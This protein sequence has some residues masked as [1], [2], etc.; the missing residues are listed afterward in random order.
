MNLK[1]RKEEVLVSL[2]N[3]TKYY[4]DRLAVDNISF[5]VG[6]G[7]ILGFLG[8]NGAGK[9]TT[10]R[11]I[12]GY[13]PPTSGKIT[14][15]GINMQENPVEAKKHIGY[16][17]E[18][19]PVYGEMTVISYLKFVARLKRVNRKKINERIEFVLQKCGLENVKNRII[20]NLSRGYRQ[21]VGI[22]Q[23]IVHDPEIIIFD[24][25]T[26][27]LDPQQVVEIRNLI[28]EISN[29][30]TVILSTH[31]L[32]EVTK[33]CDRV[34][35][36][37]Q[38]K[39]VFGKY[40]DEIGD[41]TTEEK[42]IRLVIDDREEIKKAADMISQIPSVIKVTVSDSNLLV[43]SKD[44]IRK[45]LVQKLSESNILPTEIYKERPS[46]EEIYLKVVTG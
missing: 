30:K 10:M 20:G 14:I 24:E 41:E 2:E 19:P 46:L 35:I 1:T 43:I 21:R 9:T 28:K 23:A 7:E 39:L 18:N 34:I 40:L 6:K 37:S 3:V 27:G 22:A 31:I 8:P 13:M 29:Q 45:K 15:I 38:G 26:V 16:L 44:D 4:G 12:T 33:I 5:D 11:M 17:P 42:K 36:I 32:S 25:P